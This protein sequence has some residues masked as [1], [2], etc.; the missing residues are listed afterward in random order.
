MKRLPYLLQGAE[1]Q[2]HQL[3]LVAEHPVSTTLLNEAAQTLKSLL[4]KAG[5]ASYPHYVAGHQVHWSVYVCS[6]VLF[7]PNISLHTASDAVIEQ[8]SISLPPFMQQLQ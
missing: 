8:L 1:H 6:S 2:H 4:L 7:L 3:L 5:I